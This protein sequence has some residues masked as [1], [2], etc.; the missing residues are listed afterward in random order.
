M[1]L[2][3]ANKNYSSWS[4]RAWLALKTVGV[5]FD[6]E[7]IALR[8]PGT[9]DEILIHSPSARV[10]VL[11]DGDVRVW[12]SLAICEHLNERFPLAGLWPSAPDARGMARSVSAEMHS[13]F[14]SLRANMPMNC[15]RSAPGEGRAPGVELD[16]DRIVAIWGD[17]RSQHGGGGPYLFGSLSIADC[18][19]A[20]VV[21]RFRTYGV[22]LDGVAADYMTTIEA[23][24]AFQEWVEA[25]KAETWSIADYDV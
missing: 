13:S 12:D 7:V 15:R 11:I 19:Y 17:C 5:D 14:T 3:I 1:K 18:M 22:E 6:E 4:M 25:A 23:W 9:R 24:P 20:P 8:Q 16:I 21:S 2:V 10:P